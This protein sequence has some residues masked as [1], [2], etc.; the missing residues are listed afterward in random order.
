LFDEPQGL[1][2]S[3]PCDH[4]IPLTAGAQPF[5]IQ[6]Y[7]YSPAL[8][9]EIEQ[10]VNKMLAEG[11]IRPSTS[12]F[13]SSVVMTKK[14]D[15]S[16]RFCIDYRFLNA[17]TLKSKFPLPIIDE[18]LDELSKASWFTKLDLRSGFHQILLKAGDVYKTGLSTHRGH[19]EFLVMP[20]GVTGGPG[21]FQAAMNSTL[22]PLLRHCAL[23]FLD[24]I[25]VYS[26]TF[27]EHIAHIEAVFKLLARLMESET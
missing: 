10:Q 26:A 18:F 25:L 5:V 16:W 21:S 8:K 19:Y 7:G 12:P 27:E 22:A 13:S 2:P 9:S 1:P 24:N 11:I 23:V 4:A 3:R 20:F 6:P 15:G 14:K 17:L